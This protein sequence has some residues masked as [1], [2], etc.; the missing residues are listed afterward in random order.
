MSNEELCERIQSGEHDLMEQLVNQNIGMVHK[1][2]R[3]YIS[4]VRRYGGAD[5]D[6]LEQAAVLGLLEAVEKWD[7]ARGSFLNIACY[8]MATSLRSM[9]GILTSKRMV[10]HETQPASFDAP[11]NEDTDTSLHDLIADRTAEDPAEAACRADE[12]EAVRAAVAQLQEDER[13]LIQRVYFGGEHRPRDWATRKR[14]E[15]GLRALRKN[16]RLRS[17]YDDVVSSAYRRKGIS[18]FNSTWSSVVEDAVLLMEL[19]HGNPQTCRA[20]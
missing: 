6:D 2:A 19:R 17:L 7:A 5:Y 11:T 8:Y 10:E 15:A 18:S 16:K 20:Y 13:D 12:Q 9:L 3:R 1:T 14:L 4:A